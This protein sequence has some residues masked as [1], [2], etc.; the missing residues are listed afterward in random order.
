M[1]TNQCDVEIFRRETSIDTNKLLYC[2]EFTDKV[3]FD[4]N[5]FIKQCTK[6]F[7]DAMLSVGWRVAK[8]E[9]AVY[10]STHI[11]QMLS[12]TDKARRLGGDNLHITFPVAVHLIKGTSL[13]TDSLKVPGNHMLRPLYVLFSNFVVAFWTRPKCDLQISSIYI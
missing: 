9:Q 13:V 2:T 12:V 8:N 1:E 4:S 3:L 6:E 10:N 5:Q 7:P 11:E